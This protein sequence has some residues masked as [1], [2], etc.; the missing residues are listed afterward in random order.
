VVC[1][2]REIQDDRVCARELV[3]S[4]RSGLVRDRSYSIK[5]YDEQEIV[6]LM[7]ETGFKQVQAHTGFSFHRL[8]GDYGFM[9]CRIIATGRKP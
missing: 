5:L 6:T 8:R 7:E 2:Q 1:R 3:V 9:N 4:K